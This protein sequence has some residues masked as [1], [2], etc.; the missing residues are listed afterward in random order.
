MP[1]V[2][3]S[4]KGLVAYLEGNAFIW[5]VD[6]RTKL[7]WVVVTVTLSVVFSSLYPVLFL[8]IQTILIPAMLGYPLGSQIYQ[9]RGT[10]LF[11]VIFLGLLNIVFASYVGGQVLFSFSLFGLTISLTEG[12]LFY[13]LTSTLRVFAI[14]IGIIVLTTTTRMSH[15]IKALQRFGLPY[16][17]SLLL[18]LTWRLIPEVGDGLEIV[19]D[20]QRTR[21]VEMDS[22]IFKDKLIAAQRL[23][24]PMFIL[25]MGSVNRT[26]LAFIARGLDWKRKQRTSLWQPRLFWLDWFLLSLSLIELGL[27]ITLKIMGYLS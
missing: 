14:F 15:L 27:G 22:K 7:I 24:K 19:I 16:R 2:A 4:A 17:L 23:I 10:F 21:G 1:G 26:T 8:A 3:T 13:A 9:H 12:T 11:I 20:A 5:K 25:L 6:P 18:G